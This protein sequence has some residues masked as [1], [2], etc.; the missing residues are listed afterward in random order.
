M[1]AHFG[2]LLRFIAF[3]RFKVLKIDIK[4]DHLAEGSY[5]GDLLLG[6]KAIKS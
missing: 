4:Q 6:F 3:S 1:D 2:S 5:W